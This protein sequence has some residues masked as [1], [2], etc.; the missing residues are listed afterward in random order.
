MSDTPPAADAAL[1]PHDASVQLQLSIRG[2]PPSPPPPPPAPKPRAPWLTP[3]TA[4]ILVAL[5][6]LIA[7]LT[8]AVN[9]HYQARLKLDLDR[10]AQT[11]ERTRLYLERAISPDAGAESRRQVLRFLVIQGSDADLRAWARLE[12][13]E[14]ERDLPRL[15]AEEQAL[16]DEVAE[17]RQTLAALSHEQEQ[18]EARVAQASEPIRVKLREEL[19]QVTSKL[20][21]Q[22]IAEV[23]K[24]T[25]LAKVAVKLHGPPLRPGLAAVAEPRCARYAYFNPTQAPDFALSAAARRE[26]A[27]E[28]DRSVVARVPPADATR[29]PDGQQWWWQ[30][31]S[32]T[33]CGCASAP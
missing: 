20:D 30:L 7:P 15:A 32:G 4:P 17:T 16:S 24:S 1:V 22:R 26:R 21:Q 13:D 5:L 33:T 29:S 3:V 11:D 27:R 10:Q 19:A 9:A 31:P 6:A 12:L 8:T 14:L 28:C 25:Q 18:L 23:E 2:A